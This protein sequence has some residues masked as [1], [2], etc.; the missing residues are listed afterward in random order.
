[1]NI[2]GNCTE[3]QK[4]PVFVVVYTTVF[5]VGLFLNITALVVFRYTKMRSHTT[6]YMIHLA[7]TDLLLIFSLPVRI[8][9]HLG[10]SIS[11][12]LCEGIPLFLLINM[13]GSI[14]LL[15]L[16]C[17]DRCMAV[18]FPLLPWVMEGRKKAPRICLGVW[19]LNIGISL[20]IYFIKRNNTTKD[21]CFRRHPS[22]TTQPIEVALTLSIGF[23]IPL[24]VMLLSSWA[25]IRAITRSA[26]AQTDL[27]DI[28]KIQRMVTI[29][30]AI[31]FTCFMPYHV[32]LALYAYS[33][34]APCSLLKSYRYT[35][36]VACLNAMLDPLAY[37]FTTETFRNK[38]DM[39]KVRRMFLLN[40]ESSSTRN[41]KV[42]KGAEN[43]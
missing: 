36:M 14:F 18:C 19:V 13:Y 40:N 17:F 39:D 16:I 38:V 6:V 42:S 25:M 37:Y 26:V 22:Y 8:L 41:V 12:V 9:Y 30:L 33:N 28:G 31:F 20:P 21:L 29:N 23:G 43:T 32:T 2:T 11:P 7:I 15:T 4:N 27:I 35:L 10:Y 3:E 1:M 34:V 24:V 5:T